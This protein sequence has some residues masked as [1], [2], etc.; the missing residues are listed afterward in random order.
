V[1]ALMP[2][3]LFSVLFLM[4]REF[5]SLLLNEAAGRMGVATGITLQLLAFLGIR[6]AVNLEDVS[7]RP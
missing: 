1:A 4:D 7:S 3:V 5:I 6:K 2:L